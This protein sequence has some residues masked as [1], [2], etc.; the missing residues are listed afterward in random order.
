M[1]AAE[2]TVLTRPSVSGEPTVIGVGM[3]VLDVDA[4]AAEVSADRIQIEQVVVNLLLN[5][6]QALGDNRGEITLETASSGS[7]GLSLLTKSSSRIT[8]ECPVSR[9]A[10]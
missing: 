7:S 4:V 2:G 9:A 1:R 8:P 3:Y 6:S 10:G 5:A